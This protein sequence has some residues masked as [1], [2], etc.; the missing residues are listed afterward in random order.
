MLFITNNSD[1]FRMDSELGILIFLF[2]RNEISDYSEI[3]N[4]SSKIT[5]SEAAELINQ[6]AHL[7]ATRNSIVPLRS[8]V[9]AG[10]I[11]ATN[12]S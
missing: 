1:F 6:G 7:Q 11:N 3:L 8:E 9:I 2:N 10:V 4:V 12:Q 5:E